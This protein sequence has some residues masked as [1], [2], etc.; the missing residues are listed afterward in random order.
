VDFLHHT[1]VN[2]SPKRPLMRCFKTV[3][4]GAIVAFFFSSQSTAQ[5]DETDTLISEEQIFLSAHFHY[6]RFRS[7]NENWPVEAAACKMTNVCIVDA[8]VGSASEKGDS[9]INLLLA[10]GK[11]PDIVGSGTIRQMANQFGPRGAF[12][13]LDDLIDEHAP[14]I[15]AFLED[16]PTIRDSIS[17]SDGYI[18]H[19]PYLPDGK[20]ARVFWIR[21]DWLDSLNLNVPQTVEEFE[22]ALVA[23]RD[24]DPNGNGL[25]DEI[26]FFARHWQEYI[27]L[28]TLFG[29]RSTGSDTYHDFIQIEGKISH[30]YIEDGYRD[31][32]HHLARW[33]KEGLV[34]PEIFTRGA[35]SRE[36]LL[37]ANIGGATRDW[38]PSTSM[39]NDLSNEIEGFK[40]RVMPPPANINGIQFEENRRSKVK[41]SGWAIGR[42]N[43]TPIETIRYFDFWFSP[44]G[45]RLANFGIEGEQYDMVEGKPVFKPELLAQGPVID[46]LYAIGAQIVARGFP[47]DS[48]YEVQW[49]NEI[50]LDGMA[51][52][53]NGDYLIEDFP[54]VSFNDGEQKTF[55]RYWWQILSYMLAQQKGWILGEGDIMIE[56]DDYILELERMQLDAVVGVVQSAYERQYGK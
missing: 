46:Q 24:R 31:G 16:H 37:S 35:K 51:L 23:F 4:R 6:T 28:V 26:P 3:L 44:K 2:I 14:H 47:Q 17:A 7:Y 48:S 15:K 1:A 33:Y 40:F 19:I 38:I 11:I 27:R 13:P 32:I 54:G 25:K 39:F 5:S 36:E 49:S 30:P 20:Y 34:D 56:W 21:M 42:L 29:G 8:T 43:N 22:E 9:A 45:R 41:A 53:E 10:S 50:A 12:L 52:Y 18:Y 55:D